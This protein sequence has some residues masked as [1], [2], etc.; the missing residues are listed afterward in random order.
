MEYTP[1]DVLAAL[2]GVGISVVLYFTG[3]AIGINVG[4]PTRARKICM[5]TSFV[6]AAVSGFGIILAVL[7]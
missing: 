1:N 6:V 4:H 5:R 7:L 2:I 3:L